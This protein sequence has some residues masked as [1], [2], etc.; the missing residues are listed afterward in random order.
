MYERECTGTSHASTHA[1]NAE[2]GFRAC[3][4]AAQGR[5]TTD[6]RS[7]SVDAAEQ[8]C[9]LSCMLTISV[10]RRQYAASKV[11]MMVVCIANDNHGRQ[12]MAADE[13]GYK[14][15]ASGNFTWVRLNLLKCKGGGRGDK[16]GGRDAG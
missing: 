1:I 6:Q 5:C 9:V 14:C 11:M 8:A 7:Q 4:S 15:C 16:G 3:L 13:G 12:S 10:V 2:R